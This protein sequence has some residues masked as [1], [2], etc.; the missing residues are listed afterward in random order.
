LDAEQE[1]GYLA[2]DDTR[3]V[4]VA[5]STVTKRPSV[6]V[7]EYYMTPGGLK[8]G[9]KGCFLN[10]LQWQSLVQHAPAVHAAL[11]QSGQVR[12]EPCQQ[13]ES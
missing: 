11:L 2:L 4:T 9:T 12:I 13:R 6:D 5:I 10:D 1:T 3:R 7:R 8:P